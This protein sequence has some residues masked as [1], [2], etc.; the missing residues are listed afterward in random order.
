MSLDIR[1]K[2]CGKESSKSAEILNNIG[3]IYLNKK[4]FD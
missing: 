1:N 4:D 2:V 3:N